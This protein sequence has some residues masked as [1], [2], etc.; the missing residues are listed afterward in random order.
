MPRR[1]HIAKTGSHDPGS[2][3]RARDPNFGMVAKAIDCWSVGVLGVLGHD[4]PGLVTACAMMDDDISIPDSVSDDRV[5]NADVFYLGAECF[6]GC[7]VE[8][9][10]KDIYKPLQILQPSSL[11]TPER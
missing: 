7:K 3:P 5:V 11:T 8:S 6:V 9:S 1:P 10:P 4:A 2:P